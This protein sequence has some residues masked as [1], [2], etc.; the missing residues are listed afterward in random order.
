MELE[1]QANAIMEREILAF[2]YMGKFRIRESSGEPCFKGRMSLLTTGDA[3]VSYNPD[4]R[5]NSNGLE[6]VVKGDPFGK[7]VTAVVR[8]ELNHR[9]GGTFKYS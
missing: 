9:G 1:K 7:A 6:R 8:H 3:E 5:A 2:E 4:Y